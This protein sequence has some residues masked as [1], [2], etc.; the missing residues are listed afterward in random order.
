M[1]PYISPWLVY[2]ISVLD[3][4]KFAVSGA[5]F[6]SI[7]GV[8]ACLIGWWISNSDFPDGLTVET[9]KKWSKKFLMLT[10]IFAVIEIL[11]PDKQTAIYMIIADNVT[12][13]LVDSTMEGIKS[14]I[15]YIAEVLK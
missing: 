8:I 9:C 11:I 6:V 4:V 1:E 13:D 10:I 14:L 12:P 7:V 5:L 2:L 3:S 15:D